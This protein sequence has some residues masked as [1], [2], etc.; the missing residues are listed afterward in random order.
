VTTNFN[1]KTRMSIGG[2]FYATDARLV[3]RFTMVDANTIDWTMTITSPK[4]FTQ[5]WTMTSAKPME[6]RSRPIDYDQEDSCHEGN[7][8]L[9]HLKNVYDQ[10]RGVISAAQ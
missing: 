3:E 10:A 2:D 4:V 1:G 9:I 8:D 5:P 6:R 7:V